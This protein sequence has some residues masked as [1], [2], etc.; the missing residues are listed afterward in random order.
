[1]MISHYPFH[2]LLQHQH[3][4][5]W[6][7]KGLSVLYLDS[8]SHLFSIT[9]NVSLPLS[10]I[11]PEDHTAWWNLM[12]LRQRQTVLNDVTFYPGLSLCNVFWL[13]VLLRMGSLYFF[14]D[15]LSDL[16]KPTWDANGH[17]NRSVSTPCTLVC[18]SPLFVWWYLDVL[19]LAPPNLNLNWNLVKQEHLCEGWTLRCCVCSI[20][21]SPKKKYIH[22]THTTTFSGPSP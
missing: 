1:M 6:V 18:F 12:V 20:F 4:Y 10:G 15:K 2:L 21:W 14:L 7:N 3:V 8:T 9:T 13:F 5:K 11:Q 16:P 17:S 19:I 22:T